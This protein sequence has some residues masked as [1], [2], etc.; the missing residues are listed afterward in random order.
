M[1]ALIC[2]YCGAKEFDF[3]DTIP[4]YG[5]HVCEKCGMKVKMK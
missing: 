5:G 1:S 3:D 2:L 4:P